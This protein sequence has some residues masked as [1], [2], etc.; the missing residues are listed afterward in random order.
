MPHL[1]FRFRKVF[2]SKS[3]PVPL[4]G[5]NGTVPHDGCNQLLIE[6]YGRKAA[7]K[8]SKAQYASK[9]KPKIKIFD[10]LFVAE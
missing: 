7:P 6:K 4:V 1:F 9:E 10:K 5:C 3:K 2:V 8:S